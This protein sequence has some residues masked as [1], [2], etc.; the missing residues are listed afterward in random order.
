MAMDL[1]LGFLTDLV[2][3]G[4]DIKTMLKGVKGDDTGFISKFAKSFTTTKD[5]KSGISTPGRGRGVLENWPDAKQYGVTVGY[6]GTQTGNALKGLDY[7]AKLQNARVLLAKDN[8]G[9]V[10]NAINTSNRLPRLGDSDVDESIT[11][12]AP[13]IDL[14]SPKI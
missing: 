2:S 10:Y 4:K 12:A 11:A 7:F 3:M 5:D 14:D 13:T 6:Q 1:N 8:W 9:H